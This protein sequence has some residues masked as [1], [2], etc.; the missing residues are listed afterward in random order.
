MTLFKIGEQVRVITSD[1]ELCCI[2]RVKWL[3]ADGQPVSKEA[4]LPML[5]Q[6]ANVPR[7]SLDFD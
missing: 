3:S 5:N 7:T 2:E 1:G 6:C 4:G